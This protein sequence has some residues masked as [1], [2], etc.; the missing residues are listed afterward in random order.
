MEKLEEKVHEAKL[1]KP[2]EI[3]QNMKKQG[4]TTDVIIVVTGL[5]K[6]KLKNCDL[7]F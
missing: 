7:I 6:N 5:K 3:A 2:F 4:F 1:E